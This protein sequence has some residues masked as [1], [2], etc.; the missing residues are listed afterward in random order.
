M[1]N[2]EDSNTF[3]LQEFDFK[4]PSIHTQTG[5]VNHETSKHGVPPPLPPQKAQGP[6]GCRR[7]LDR[8]RFM[9]E[10]RH[11]FQTQNCLRKWIPL[12]K[13]VGKLYVH[14]LSR[15]YSHLMIEFS[16]NTRRWQNI[17][18]EEQTSLRDFYNQKPAALI[19][20]LQYVSP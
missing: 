9:A 18:G 7:K 13:Q 14:T 17:L 11:L 20:T 12:A 19:L 16:A 15:Q 3:S 2:H 8:S 1:S 5:T 4:I 10:H 6:S